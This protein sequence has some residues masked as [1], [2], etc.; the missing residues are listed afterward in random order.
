MG[1]IPRPLLVI[2][3][4]LSQRCSKCK[5]VKPL[6]DFPPRKDRPSGRQYACRACNQPFYGLYAAAA[7]SRDIPTE[8]LCTACGVVKSAGDFSPRKD[9]PTG[10]H[11]HCKA[12]RRD[13]RNANPE[14]DRVRARQ[15]YASHAEACKSNV[16]AYLANH[17]EQAR[18][19]RKATKDRHRERYNAIER[20]R[21]ATRRAADPEG[22]RA[23]ARAYYQANPAKHRLRAMRYYARKISNGGLF[24]EA[25]WI[26]LKA[27]F[28]HTC[29]CCGRR[30]PDIRLSPDHIVPIS[31]GGLNVAS[32]I[33]PL[34]ERCNKSKGARTIDY[35]S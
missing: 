20:E 10:L 17:P 35:R 9:H 21:A 11:A 32:N 30:E 24:T 7:E 22:N 6:T 8:K 13:T 28:E 26:T 16:R 19:W 4:I 3:G 1:R 25:E 31:K 33:Q 34:C 2:D 23:K 27:R 5:V 18:M 12:C 15:Y 29:L 14:P